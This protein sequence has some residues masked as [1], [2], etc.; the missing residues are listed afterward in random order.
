MDTQLNSLVYFHIIHELWLILHVVA[1]F[2]A[3]QYLRIGISSE[4]SVFHENTDFLR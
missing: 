2:K 3:T 1:A 4:I